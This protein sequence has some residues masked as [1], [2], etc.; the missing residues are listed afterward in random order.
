MHRPNLDEGGNADERG[1]ADERESG[2]RLPRT[3]RRRLLSGA[4]IAVVAGGLA[5]PL[6]SVSAADATPPTQPANLRVPDETSSTVAL[7]WDTATDEGGSGLDR[8]EVSVDGEVDHEV[9]VGTTET[10]V[11]DLPYDR[12]FEFAVVAVDGAGNRSDPATVEAWTDSAIYDFPPAPPEQ[13]TAT[14]ASRTSV[15]VAWEPVDRLDVDHVGWIVLVNGAADHSVP[16]ETTETTVSGLDAGAT[17]EIAVVAED[18]SGKRSE[19]VIDRAA[20]G[21]PNGPVD[22]VDGQAPRDL[23]GDGHHWDLDTDGELDWDDVVTYF[24]HR[25]E[26]A[27]QDHLDAYDFNENGRIDSEDVVRLFESL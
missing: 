3:T 16:T 5:G 20:P 22:P 2:G 6:G 26:P 11:T 1:Y 24:E 4:S 15:D 17:Y 21:A 18:E 12:R 7:A 23:D 14:A 19:P 13:V 25:H 10:T 27:I 9:A 8:Y